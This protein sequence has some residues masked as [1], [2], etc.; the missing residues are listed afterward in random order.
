MKHSILC[1]DDEL[2]NLEALNR[3]FRKSYDIITVLSG[4]QAL[5]ELDKKKFSLII[6]D[7][8]MPEMTGVEFFMKAKRIQPDAV[9][10]LLT[11]Y[12]DLES[13]INAINQ[14]QI[15]RYITKPWEPREFLS[16]ASQATEVFEM[17]Q[18]I[19]Q[20][21]E[22][23]LQANEELKSL[24]KMKMDFMLLV[25]HELKT[26]LTG[27]FSFLQL[28][29]EE[30]LN[31]E[32]KFYVEKISKNTLRLQD[33][34][35]STLLI[36]HLKI[37][38]E[39][40]TKESLNI[41]RLIQNQWKLLEPDF[42]KKNLKLALTNS[43]NFQQSGNPKYIGIVIKKLLH[44]SFSHSKANTE[45]NFELFD[46]T[47]N[48]G[49]KTQNQLTKELQQTPRQLLEA[50]STSEKILNHSGGTG[51]GLAVIQTIVKLFGGKILIESKDL[52]FQLKITLPKTPISR[53]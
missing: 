9:R 26:P 23:L 19:S 27:I 52:K 44:N 10:I 8:K 3:L 29:S 2:Y 15:Y 33:L 35:D 47:K 4:P 6:S 25:N 1:I 21:N 53:I 36:T 32:Q 14:G 40:L 38:Q 48:W 41:P 42:K 39:I 24:N 28:L 50:F 7:Q 20:Q 22:R 34:I 13:V 11:G 30:S 43:E 37:N 16:I 46:T 51:L 5:E 18:T 17:K 49:I 12:T 31:P 45:V